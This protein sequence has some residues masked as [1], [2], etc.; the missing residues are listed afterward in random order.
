MLPTAISRQLP[1]ALPE[2]VGLALKQRAPYI[3]F[4]ALFLSIVLG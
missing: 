2:L 4:G 1:L 3:T